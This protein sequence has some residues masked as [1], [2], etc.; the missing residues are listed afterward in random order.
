[1]SRGVVRKP[2]YSF[3]SAQ[4]YR[5]GEHPEVPSAGQT[6]SLEAQELEIGS[7]PRAVATTECVGFSFQSLTSKRRP[8]QR[9]NSCSDHVGRTVSKTRLVYDCFV[10]KFGGL[11]GL[12][13]LLL[14]ALRWAL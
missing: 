1:M 2:V 10:I 11:S 9:L 7:H 12:W 8:V 5:L 14:T 13:K 6:L 3:V 4:Q